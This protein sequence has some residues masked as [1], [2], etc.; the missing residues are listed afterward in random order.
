MYC[1]GLYGLLF[2]NFAWMYVCKFAGSGDR[3][4]CW[5][6]PLSSC[7]REWGEIKTELSGDWFNQGWQ[8]SLSIFGIWGLGLDLL[9]DPGLG[10][11]G[12]LWSCFIWAEL[13]FPYLLNG[14][15]QWMFGRMKD[16][17]NERM[18][19]RT[20]EWMNE[21]AHV[22]TEGWD[23]C[24]SKSATIHAHLLILL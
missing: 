9:G 21:S 17:T 23:G 24:I 3:C 6:M 20:N 22:W 8:Q 16:W 4:I 2:T 10:G 15:D 19:Q 13:Q 12:D 1:A 18:N 7:L 11:F 14:K 5:T